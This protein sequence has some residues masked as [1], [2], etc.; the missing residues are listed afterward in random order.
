M[1]KLGTPKF[2]VTGVSGLLDHFLNRITSIHVNLPRSHVLTK[3]MAVQSCCWRVRGKSTWRKNVDSSQSSV[4]GAQRKYTIKRYGRNK[5]WSELQPHI[6]Q[7]TLFSKSYSVLVC[8]LHSA[9][10]HQAGVWSCGS[11]VSQ[12]LW[13][14]AAKERGKHTDSWLS[15]VQYAFIWY[16]V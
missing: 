8:T 10:T 15:C 4:L 11:L 9:A 1:M 14:E 13:R 16:L 6:V 5:F 12:R 3:N 2:Y 7:V